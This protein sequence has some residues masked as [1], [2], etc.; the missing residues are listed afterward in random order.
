[1][2]VDYECKKHKM[3]HRKRLR[4]RLLCGNGKGLLD[5]EVLE[6]ILCSSHTRKDMKPIAKRLIDHFGNFSK[7]FYADVN[8]LKEVLGVGEISIA[9]IFC[10][11]EALN[12]IHRGNIKDCI[13]LNEWNKLIEYLKVRIG[14]SNIE[15]F[16]VLY[17]NK[18]YHLIAD[19]VQDVGT[20][21]ETP[22]YV[23]EVIKRVLY[24][25]ATSIIIAHNHPSGDPS[26][27]QA[28]INVTN[29][30]LRVCLSMNINLIDHVIV[31]FDKHYSF[32]SHGLL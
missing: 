32:K 18:K 3:G 11:R 14:N 1:M 26:P 25:S 8:E 22:I 12:R 24:L 13:I 29:R 27:S 2:N 21:D 16:H 4:E 9:A 5:Y 19:E 30:L 28:D 31:A 23:R 15:N 10:V 20:I 17:L 7:V 6:L